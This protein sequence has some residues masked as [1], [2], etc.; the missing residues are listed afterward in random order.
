MPT[1]KTVHITVDSS[2]NVSAE[3]N[4]LD[5]GKSN[6][7]VII[8]FE[9]DTSDCE[10]TGVSGLPDDEFTEKGKNGNG[11]KVKDKN[12]NTKTYDYTVQF[13]RTGSDT[14]LK[15]DPSIKNGGQQ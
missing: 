11:W 5:V 12:D 1:T 9:M 8:N 10:I 3:P 14:V 2:G 15:H 6:G 4:V 13:Q 7:S